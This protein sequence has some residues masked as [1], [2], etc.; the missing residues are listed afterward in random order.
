VGGL[1]GDVE[2]TWAVRL[3][4]PLGAV[5]GGLGCAR[6]ESEDLELKLE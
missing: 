6:V 3:G 1:V 4:G 2:V 5:G